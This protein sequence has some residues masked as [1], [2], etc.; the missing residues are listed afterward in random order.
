[1]S[2][3]TAS[4][5]GTPAR[6]G[7]VLASLILG[8]FVCNV[9]LSVA[10]VALPDIGKAFSASQ[11]SLTLVAV[12]CTLG[13]AMS[14]LYFGAI[15]DRYGR[16]MMLLLGLAITIPAALIST[17]APTVEI[18]QLGRLLT[19]LAAG[20]AYPTTLAL[21]TALWAEG[22]KRTKAIAM[23]QAVSGAS[24]VLGP[25]LAGL[26]LEKL[27]WGSVFLIVI[28]FAIIAFI[29]NLLFVPAHVAESTKPVD[30]LGGVLSAIMIAG[31]VLGIGMISSPGKLADSL[32][33]IGGSLVV[34]VLFVVRQR[35]TNHPLYD[36]NYAK[37]RLFWVPAVA[38][39]IVMGSL[40]GAMYVGQQFL[41]NVMGYD[42]FTAGI[43]ILP[44]AVGMILVAPQSAKLIG[45]R[46]SRFTMLLG[47]CFVLPAFLI[48]LLTWHSG[49]SY[50]FIGLA[51]LL[52]GIGVGFALTPAARSL[53]SSVPV[54]K[55][56][57]ASGTS[58]LQRDL[59]G[60]VFQAV[61]GT[62][63]TLGYA[64]SF[65]QQVAA[66][67]DA[68]QVSAATQSQLSASYASATKVAEQFPEYQSA[69]VSAAQE[70]FLQGAGWAY[71]A[72]ALFIVMGAL[73]VFFAYP[74][75]QKALDLFAEYEQE[76]A[77]VTAE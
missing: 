61:L 53:T 33:L 30:H 74:S 47:Y 35:K 19:G 20:M 5:T 62:F 70:S 64:A 8:A 12:G 6:S 76:D 18:L 17:F 43:A 14:V 44:A 32:L 16:K 75:K 21:V 67:P 45:A 36:P 31:V 50:F 34:V 63:L 66:S 1:M 40:A 25:A 9:N 4:K 23:W 60:S 58:D 72:G 3:T 77:Q 73:L 56:G 27:W 26:F 55:V 71:A 42:T 68:S 10:N 54:S 13:L 38:G 15:G 7:L 59:G 11:T 28:P 41:Q 57:M 29:M 49:V 46:G 69:I 51:Y 2:S 52:M 37:R 22:A 24:A 65:S 39:M 48:M